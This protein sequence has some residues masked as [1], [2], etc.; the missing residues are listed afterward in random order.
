MHHEQELL[1]ALAV[2]CGIALDYYDIWGNRHTISGQTK[3]AIL[4]AMGLRVATI[5]ELQQELSASEDDP[6]R[7]LCDVVLVRR[8]EEAAATWAVRLPSEEPDDREVRIV[9]ELR[10]ESGCLQQQGVWGP[11]LVPAETRLIGGHRHVRFDLPI[12]TG[13]AFGYYDLTARA[14]TVSGSM[15]GALRL[16]IVPSRCYV[17][18]YFQEGRRTWG[19]ALHLYALRSSRNWGVGDFGDLADFADWAAKDLGAGVI[20]L[21]PLHALKNVRPYHISPYSPDSRFFLNVL[22]LAVEEIPELR[23]SE[24]AQRL[25]EDSTFRSRLESFRKHDL[26]DYDQVYAAKREVLE[27]LFATFLTHHL[28]GSG[29]AWQPRTDRG[30]A[31]ERFVREEGELL[32]NFALFHALSE[33]LHRAFPHLWTWQEWPEAYRDPQSAAVAAFRARQGA[34]IRFHQY[35]QWVAS[36]QLER[37]A[38][39]ARGAGMPIGLYHDLALGSDRSGSDAWVFQ[40]VLALGADSGCPPDAFAP[41]GQNWGLPPINPRQLRAGAYRMFT[42][43]LRNNL[44]YGGALR[45]DHVMGLF[46]LFWIPRGLPASAGAYVHYPAE[47]LLGILALESQRSKTIIVGE[48]LG[49]VPDSVRERL[50][51]ASVLS[52]RVLYFERYGDGSW[53]EPRAYPE[54]ALAVVTTHDLPTLSGFWSAEDIQTRFKLGFYGSDVERDQ[55]LRERERDRGR[56]LGALRAEGLLPAGMSDDPTSATH[57]TPELCRAIHIF[58]AR[59]PAWIMLASLED[60]LGEMAQMNVPGTVDSYPN[61]LRKI[62][63]SLGELKEDCA[64][65]LLAT[66]LREAR[67]AG[68]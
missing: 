13:L 37:A 20:G 17:P 30:R 59:T 27:L 21:N 7:H 35:L 33:E 10:D 41:E 57:L 19:L 60:C 29:E 63:L 16:I 58:L 67:P 66:S 22:Y 62:R 68:T 9:W 36:E 28:D 44:A 23:E 12:P 51:A 2:R 48:D 6:W 52:Y 50:A 32:E 56:L 5:E 3:R 54:R 43:L 65:R 55:A 49:T 24:A 38:A 14:E 1:D 46:R 11:G 45:L 18:Q 25:L 40:D 53:K 31:F 42:A 47:D 15:E 34:R 26:V 61:W 8:A 39:R 4:A 64:V